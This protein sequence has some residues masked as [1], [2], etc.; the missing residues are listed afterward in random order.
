LLVLPF[1]AFQAQDSARLALLIGNQGHSAKVG[2]AKVLAEELLK[3]GIEAARLCGRGSSQ[4]A[5]SSQKSRSF[6]KDRF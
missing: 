6:V 4:C 1:S 2:R 5:L 3:P